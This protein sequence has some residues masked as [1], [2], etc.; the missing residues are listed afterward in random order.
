[1]QPVFEVFKTNNGKWRFK[2]RARNGKIIAISV[3]RYS[4][5][6]GAVLGIRNIQECAP[7]SIILYVDN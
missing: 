3:V 5:R 6:S 4:T 2:L 1:M 7:D